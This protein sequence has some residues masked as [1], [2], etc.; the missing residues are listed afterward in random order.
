VNNRLFQPDAEQALAGLKVIDLGVI[1]AGPMLAA[2]LADFGADVIK[3]EHPKGDPVRSLGWVKDG[4]SLWWSHMNRNKRC[5][6]LNL[7]KPEGAALL[8][9]LVADADVL[10]ESFRPGTMERW[11]LGYDELSRI[12]PGLVM[13]RTSGYGQTGPRSSRPGFGTVA[14][15]MSG[16][17][18]I[19]GY[20]DG[21]PTLP[22][23][24]LGDGIAALY[25]VFATFVALRHRD[26]APPHV[27]QVV[28]VSLIEPLF[29]FLGPQALLYDQLGEVQTRT[30][31]S[32][33]W[34]SPR[35]VYR[36]RDGRWVAVSASAQSVAERVVT[37]V[38]RP[39][40]AQE[41]WFK[42]H[43]GRVAHQHELD[44]IIGTWI[45]ERT[46]DEVFAAFAEADAVAG[47]VYSIVDILEDP[48]F[49]SREIITEIDHPKLGRVRTTNVVPRLSRTPG[50]VHHLGRNL[51]EDNHA[52]F[53]EQLAHDPS[54]LDRWHQEGVI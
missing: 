24:A 37:L 40:L 2:L 35:S 26:A 51:G 32:T 44:E 54:E 3:V 7:S 1:I 22:P 25:G 20:A 19:N 29:A 41:P 9:E 33:T 53:V 48:Q 36:D 49:S 42:D 52:V 21:P 46:Q 8:K 13:V 30:G 39:D 34:T 18:H 45:A 15:A 4:V 50:R 23:I 17:A 14:E 31:N 28:D 10:V 47:P 38:G 6:S 11:G 12:N 43:A 27:G 16:F 5:I